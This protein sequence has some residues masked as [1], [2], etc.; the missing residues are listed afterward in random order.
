MMDPTEAND[1]ID[2]SEAS[3]PIEPTDRAEPMQPI[4]ST[5]P[6]DPMD[7]TDPFELIDRIERAEP[8]FWVDARASV[9]VMSAWCTSNPRRVALCEAIRV[10]SWL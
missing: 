8:F 7:S 10:R 3:D 6:V 4:D 2:P 1:A 9:E 5:D